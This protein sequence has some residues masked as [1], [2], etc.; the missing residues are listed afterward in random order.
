MLAG[1]ALGQSTMVVGGH[2]VTVEHTRLHPH[3]RRQPSRD[4]PDR[5]L[6]RPEQRASSCSEQEKVGVTS[7]GVHYSENME[8]TLTS[9]DP[10]H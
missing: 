2:A 8:A 10:A 5:L 3:L 9:L 7:G 1:E 6:D 4:Q